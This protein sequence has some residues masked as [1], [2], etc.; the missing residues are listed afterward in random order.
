M[1]V[2]ATLMRSRALYLLLLVRRRS[3]A[4][5]AGRL[6]LPDARAACSL[7]AMLF[8]ILPILARERC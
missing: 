6:P 7:G 3:F 2:Y 8:Y 1:L 4:A 5:H